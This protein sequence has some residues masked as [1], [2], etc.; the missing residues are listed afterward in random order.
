MSDDLVSHLRYYAELGV[1]GVSR[2]PAWRLAQIAR[3]SRRRPTKRDADREPQ[4]IGD[5]PDGPLPRQSS[6]A[7]SRADALA[8]IRADI[9]DC[10]RCKLHSAARNLVY[11]VGSPDA[12]AHVCRRRSRR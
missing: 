9:G 2:D 7:R 3:A 6:V 1:D 5:R 12:D 4:S 10:T 11:G 8:A